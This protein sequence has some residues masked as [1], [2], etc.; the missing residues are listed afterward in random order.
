M[1]TIQTNPNELSDKRALITGETKGMREA[2]VK[3]IVG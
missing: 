2:I 1:T 3:R